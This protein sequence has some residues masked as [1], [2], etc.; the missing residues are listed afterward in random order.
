MEAFQGETAPAPSTSA[1]N[2]SNGHSEVVNGEAGSDAATKNGASQS[3]GA[4]QH[5]G[6]GMAVTAW[7]AV[8]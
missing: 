1:L 2:G 3:N 8:A 7:M 6:N 4:R 5:T